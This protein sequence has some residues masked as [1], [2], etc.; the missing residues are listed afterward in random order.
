VRGFAQ[1]L[2]LGQRWPLPPSGVSQWVGE[3]NPSEKSLMNYIT[4]RKGKIIVNEIIRQENLEVELETFY[5]KYCPTLAA[6]APLRSYNRIPHLPYQ[7]YYSEQWMIDCV[8]ERNQD[9]IEH[10]GYEFDS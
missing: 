10:F 7:D 3:R 6:P 5:K 8:A 1:S 4:D 9:Y 2:R